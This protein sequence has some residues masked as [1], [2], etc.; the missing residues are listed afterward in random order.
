MNYLKDTN[1]GN[2]LAEIKTKSPLVWNIS[3]FVS[4][5]IAANVLL[6]IGAS[7]AMDHAIEEAKSF[8]N[9]SKSIKAKKGK[10]L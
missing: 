6:S 8:E 10:A 7:P 9:L 3:N 2:L 4:M 1:A 5:D